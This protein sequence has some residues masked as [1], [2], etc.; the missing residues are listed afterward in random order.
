[1]CQV[2]HS[3]GVHAMV[4]S[5][6]CLLNKHGLD[7]V[8]KVLNMDWGWHKMKFFLYLAAAPMVLK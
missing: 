1:M 2:L 8:N 5:G 3:H 6:I 4:R 7:L